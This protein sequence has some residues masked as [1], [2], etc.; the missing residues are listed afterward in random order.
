MAS[1][2]NTESA[3]PFVP[4][5]DHGSIAKYCRT[6]KHLIHLLV[7]QRDRLPEDRGYYLMPRQEEDLQRY[8]KVLDDGGQ[9]ET[10]REALH[11]LCYGL[12]AFKLPVNEKTEHPFHIYTMGRGEVGPGGSGSKAAGGRGVELQ[13]VALIH[14]DMHV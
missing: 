6:M 8:L 1:Y 12:Y 14:E 3:Y 5:N 4:L 7:A 2:S 9:H 13:R 11:R 10:R